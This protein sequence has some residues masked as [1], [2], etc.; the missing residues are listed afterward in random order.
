M[1]C[2]TR[3]SGLFAH[4]AGAAVPVSYITPRH[5]KGLLVTL[6]MVPLGMVLGDFSSRAS[7]RER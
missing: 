3:R 2:V 5:T 6:A 7:T 4:E 1:T